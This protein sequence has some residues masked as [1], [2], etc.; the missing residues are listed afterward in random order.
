MSRKPTTLLL[1]DGRWR[2]RKG[3]ARQLRVVVCERGCAATCGDL[4][5]RAL[6]GLRACV[7]HV[8][9]PRELRRA[10]WVGVGHECVRTVAPGWPLEVAVDREPLPTG[11]WQTRGPRQCGGVRDDDLVEGRGEAS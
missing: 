2:R 6:D 3:Q 9:L 4:D 1:A 11:L 5:C 10:Q 8:G 7:D